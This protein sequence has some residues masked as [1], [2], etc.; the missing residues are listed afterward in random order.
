MNK[1][2][3]HFCCIIICLLSGCATQQNAAIKSSTLKQC[4][5]VCTQ[6]LHQC[7][8]QC[9]NNCRT[10]SATSSHSTALSYTK[11]VHERQIEG[12][13]VARELNSYRDPLQCRK[14]TCNCSADFNM[15]T[16]NC[17]GIIQKKLSAVSF[18]T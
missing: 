1:L 18:C 10:C 5:V 8:N 4:N 15:C 11:Y 12:T 6:R 2:M 3:L 13:I 7:S 16:Q 17:T 9:V 14:I